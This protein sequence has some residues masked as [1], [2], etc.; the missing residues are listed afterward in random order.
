MLLGACRTLNEF[1]REVDHRVVATAGD[2]QQ[3]QY[4]FGEIQVEWRGLWYAGGESLDWKLFCAT[5][6]ETR[7]KKEGDSK[8]K[9]MIETNLIAED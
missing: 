6:R 3:G 2:S 1:I 7:D 4:S 9:C 5:S 8:D